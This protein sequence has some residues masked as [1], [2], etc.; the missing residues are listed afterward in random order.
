[1]KRTSVVVLAI[2]V[3]GAVALVVLGGGSGLLQAE[4]GEDPKPDGP[5]PLVID[6][7]AP[8]LLDEPEDK[9]KKETGP[10]ADNTACYVCH[11]NYDEEELVLIHAREEVGCIDCHGESFDH[12]DDEDNVTPPD[13]MYWPEAID[14]ACQ[15]CHETHDVSA[16]EVLTRWKERC[17]DKTDAGKIVCTD[18]H[19]Y[20]RLAKRSVRWNKKTGELILEKKKPAAAQDAKKA[21]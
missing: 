18:C 17:P 3:A 19:G 12:R 21:P 6:R 1:M 8:L 16:R 15:E 4:G 13:T 9:P 7:N 11:G 10:M 2:G 20:H 5:P 14:P